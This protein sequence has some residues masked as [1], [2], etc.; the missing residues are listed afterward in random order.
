MSPFWILL[1]PRV[2]D[3]V[4]TTGAKRRIKLQSY[5]YHQQTSTQL[6]TGSMPFLSPNQQRQSNVYNFLNSLTN[7]LL[8]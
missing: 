7:H 8:L 4:V 5:H 2:M 3:V 6:F 1:E